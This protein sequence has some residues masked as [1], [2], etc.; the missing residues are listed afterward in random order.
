MGSRARAVTLSGLTPGS[1][2]TD[3]EP[4]ADAL[5]TVLAEASAAA[6]DAVDDY[7]RDGE[8]D[9]EAALR[10]L[11]LGPRSHESSQVATG[12]VARLSLQVRTPR[13]CKPS[14][15]GF[16]FIVEGFASST[17]ST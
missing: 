16:C 10:G 1:G 5:G 3:L 8:G 2:T 15:T 7:V 17:R 14:G 12:S 11:G 4:F 13:A 6:A 9:P